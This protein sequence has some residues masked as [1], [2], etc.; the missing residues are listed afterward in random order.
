MLLRAISQLVEEAIFRSIDSHCVLREPGY[1]SAGED[2]QN[3]R[4]DKKHT[5]S[6][7]PSCCRRCVSG[8]SDN[9]PGS[10]YPIYYGRRGREAERGSLCRSLRRLHARKKVVSALALQCDRG[11]SFLFH[12]CFSQR[13]RKLSI[14]SRQDSEFLFPLHY[15]RNKRRTN[16]AVQTFNLFFSPVV[17]RLQ[18]EREKRS[19]RVGKVH[20]TQ[21]GKEIFYSFKSRLSSFRAIYSNMSERNYEKKVVLMKLYVKCDIKNRFWKLAS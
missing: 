16:R 6:S 1:I 21:Y 8:S 2:K 14:V 3:K 12:L 5:F 19:E 7:S 10:F 4:A 17:F 11:E 15:G 9:T 18:G 20:C 13:L